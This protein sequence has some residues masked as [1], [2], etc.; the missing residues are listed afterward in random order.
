[1]VVITLWFWG[2]GT[3]P[4]RY[5]RAIRTKLPHAKVVIMSDDVHHIRLQRMAD[6]DSRPGAASLARNET[7]EV[8]EEEL[9]W[10]YYA[11]SR[12]GLLGW[13]WW[14][15]LLSCQRCRPSGHV[16]PDACL[17]GFPARSG[18]LQLYR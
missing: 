12:A 1:M 6:R 16:M 17:A 10:Y 3:M 4:S 18:R 9:K 2:K 13:G 14:R 8:K 7:A 15:G 5:L 11:G